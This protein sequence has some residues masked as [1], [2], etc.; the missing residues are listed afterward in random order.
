MTIIISEGALDALLKRAKPRFDAEVAAIL[1]RL[2][3]SR[4]GEPAA[5]QPD[6]D[7][8]SAPA[9]NSA[10]R[11]GLAPLSGAGV[12]KVEEQALLRRRRVVERPEQEAVIGLVGDDRVV[13]D[14]RRQRRPGA[15]LARACPAF[16]RTRRGEP[17][18]AVD[19]I[20]EGNAA[21]A[22]DA[23]I[24]FSFD[25]AIGGSRD[26]VAVISQISR[27]FAACRQLQRRAPDVVE[28]VSIASLN[29]DHGIDRSWRPPAVPPAAAFWGSARVPCDGEI[30]NKRA[31][32]TLNCDCWRHRRGSRSIAAVDFSGVGG[33]DVTE[34]QA[35]AVLTA[36]RPWL[37][38]RPP[39]HIFR[40]QL[41]L[42]VSLPAAFQY[43]EGHRRATDEAFRQARRSAQQVKTAV[44]AMAESI[45]ARNYIFG[46]PVRKALIA[47]NELEQA[48]SRIPLEKEQRLQKGRAPRAWY[49]VF[50][51]EL[52]EIAKEIGLNV[53][54]AGDRTDNAHATPF[55]QF[56]FAV[57]LRACDPDDRPASPCRRLL[58]RLDLGGV[59]GDHAETVLAAVATLVRSRDWGHL[60]VAAVA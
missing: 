7:R 16:W 15:G 1:S 33:P 52:G 36:I 13:G 3:K 12:P 40:S 24:P 31:D 59:A 11:P 27:I 35:E 56:V 20:G 43:F 47:V 5:V 9:A 22:G 18:G 37:R 8:P 23:F 26:G 42:L 48:L 51:H 29:E 54:T 25:V 55:T 39:I 46:P 10:A 30:G 50:V 58:A 19:A 34:I 4:D 41:V 32:Q 6:H 44:Q 49:M 28:P 21:K 38:H 2:R 14:L 17:A 57:A 53:T 60:P 45:F